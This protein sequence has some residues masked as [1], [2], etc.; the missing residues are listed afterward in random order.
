MSLSVFSLPAARAVP[1]DCLGVAAAPLL[2]RALVRPQ[3][4]CGV[5]LCGVPR[6]WGGRGGRDV[7]SSEGKT[8]CLSDVGLRECFVPAC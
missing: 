5:V 7:S 8:L 4:C 2:C 6:L 3:C 1:W